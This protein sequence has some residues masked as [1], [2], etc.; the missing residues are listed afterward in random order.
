MRL[1]HQFVFEEKNNSLKIWFTGQLLTD[2]CL[3]FQINLA[4]GIYFK[5]WTRLKILWNSDILSGKDFEIPGGDGM[6][7]LIIRKH[8]IR[9]RGEGGGGSCSR[10]E[11]PLPLGQPLNSSLQLKLIYNNNVQTLSYLNVV[12]EFQ[13]KPLYLTGIKLDIFWR[14]CIGRINHEILYSFVKFRNKNICWMGFTDWLLSGSICAKRIYSG[15]LEQQVKFY[16]PDRT[17][18]EYLSKCIFEYEKHL[19]FC[20]NSGSARILIWEEFRTI[21]THKMN[22]FFVLHVQ[23]I[24]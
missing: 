21:V 24:W 6:W 3:T 23:S 10:R 7:Y 19:M 11:C 9:S 18:Y 16:L 15:V 17:R 22:N 20:D 4:P 13:F 12:S 5:I 2:F 1:G 8:N 14:I